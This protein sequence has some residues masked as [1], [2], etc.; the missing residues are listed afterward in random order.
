ML[1]KQALN[2]MKKALF[3]TLA[4]YATTLVFAQNFGTT[5]FAT[6][7]RND[8]I[9]GTYYGSNALREAYNA[10]IDSDIVTLSAGHFNS[11]FSGYSYVQKNITIRGTGYDTASTVEVLPTYL[12]NTFHIERPI[13]L[14][15]VYCTSTVY[16]N[17]SNIRFNKCRFHQIQGLVSTHSQCIFTNCLISSW[18]GQNT[19]QTVFTNC[20]I[21]NSY[22]N[23]YDI[24]NNC[25][26]GISPE[27][28]NYKEIHNSITFSNDT[29][30][31]G[32]ATNVY[33]TVGIRA[34]DTAQ[35][36]ANRAGRNNQTIHSFSSI[37]K[38][39][40]GTYT[41]GETFELQ[42]NI[43]NTLLGSD[44]TQIGIYGGA[45]PFNNRVTDPRIIG[46]SVDLH[47]NAN[48]QI[49]VYINLRN[50]NN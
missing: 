27:L 40:S 38:T 31:V 9:I 19:T 23:S 11:T 6:L 15:G 45:L 48:G 24:Y 17:T 14:E 5:Q 13:L 22:S 35:F 33:Y 32:N 10:A 43:V 39:F 34:Q 46:H 12:D 20:V 3:L 37:F 28:T 18:N 25:I 42:D 4:L 41:K 26:I 50:S 29:T 2:I 47:S 16:M 21:L 7:S 36:Y 49:N 8:S 44:S 30:G 1:Y